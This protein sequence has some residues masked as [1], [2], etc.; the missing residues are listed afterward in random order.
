MIG[1]ITLGTNDI[2]RAAKFYDALLAEFGATRVMESERYIAWGTA[3]G[4][5]AL[6]VIEPYDGQ[7]ATVGNG[8]MVA[9][10]AENPEKVQA[11]YN[12]AVELGASDE[13][14]PGPRGEGGFYGGYFRDL[15]GNKLNAFCLG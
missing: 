3:P 8:V 12:K 2:D 11:V 1:Y 5:T 7:P 6:S 14:A 15:D 13:G 10:H 4:V 9:L